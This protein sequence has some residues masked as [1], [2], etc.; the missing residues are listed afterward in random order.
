M[1]GRTA[2]LA[3][4]LSV[5]AI[6]TLGCGGVDISQ[7]GP[8]PLMLLYLTPHDK[9]I[10][11]APVVDVVA[12]FSAPVSLGEGD[13]N[14]NERTFFVRVDGGNKLDDV[15]TLSKLDSEEGS[16][17]GSTA[18]IRLDG[19]EAGASYSIFVSGKLMGK[20]T[21][22]MGVDVHSSFTVFTVKQ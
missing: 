6:E 20:D 9:E 4:I 1:L 8:E 12:V 3:C 13:S 21:G 15:V 22:P 11:I 10:D 17:M 2:I 7:Q 5:V 18:V 14:L 16:D 19:L